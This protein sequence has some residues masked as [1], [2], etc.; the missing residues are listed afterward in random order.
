MSLENNTQGSHMYKSGT[1]SVKNTLLQPLFSQINSLKC[2]YI[3]IENSFAAFKLWLTTCQYVE[4]E[5]TEVLVAPQGPNLVIRVI[6][7]I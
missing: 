4:H 1:R 6:L 2:P 5:T 3:P 7:D